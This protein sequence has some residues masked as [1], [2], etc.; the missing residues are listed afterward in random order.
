MRDLHLSRLVADPEDAIDLLTAYGYRVPD[1]EREAIAKVHGIAKGVEAPRLLAAYLQFAKGFARM[2]H[3]IRSFLY[4]FGVPARGQCQIRDAG[5]LFELEGL[6]TGWA[7]TGDL[8]EDGEAGLAALASALDATVGQL[9]MDESSE[10]R[11]T[12]REHERVRQMR[13][14]GDPRHLVVRN[15]LR[16]RTPELVVTKGELKLFG[17]IA[18]RLGEDVAVFAAS[19]TFAASLDSSAERVR[20][21]AEA[22]QQSGESI[23]DEGPSAAAEAFEDEVA[24]LIGLA[25]NELERLAEGERVVDGLRDF[26]QTEFWFQRWRI[27]ELWVLVRVLRLLER[28][29][30]R[31]RLKQVDP[32][33]VWQLRYGR[34]TEP[35]AVAAFAGGE[36]EGSGIAQALKFDHRL[37]VIRAE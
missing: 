9:S 24:V 30:G 14:M 10:F 34:S 36:I 19:P 27:Y 18:D 7:F 37:D 20:T 32:S 8:A 13:E 21:F 6:E 28:A 29:G 22:L 12:N 1:D 26:V 17:R 31:L 3:E 5:A 23:V 15:F 33:G 11:S 35:C 16:D 25:R 2:S 4:D